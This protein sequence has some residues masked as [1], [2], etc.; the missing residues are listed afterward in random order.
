MLR[1]AKKDHNY[2]A[3]EDNFFCPIIGCSVSHSQKKR[4]YEHLNESHNI[5]I[6]KEI[7]RFK[8]EEGNQHL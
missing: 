8:S 3:P 5:K 6:N 2:K 4:L 1:H 7:L